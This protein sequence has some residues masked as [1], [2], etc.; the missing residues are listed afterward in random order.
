MNANLNIKT[1][2]ALFAIGIAGGMAGYGLTRTI[3]NTTAEKTPAENARPEATTHLASMPTYFASAAPTEFTSAAEKC[4]DGVVHVKTKYVQ[5]NQMYGN[6]FYQ[7][8]FGMPDMQERQQ[9]A[10]ASGSGVIISNDGYIVTNNHVIEN[11]SSIEVVLNDRR[12]YE[13]Q[14][15]GRDPSTDIALLKINAESLTVIPFG[16]SDNLKIG[17]WVVAIGNPFN[18]TSTVTA[19][20]VSAKG[21][22]NIIGKGGAVESFIQT[23]AAVNPG[24]SG[25]ALVNTEGQLVGINTAIASQTGNFAGYAFAV[26]TSIVQKVISDLMEYG[27]VQRALIGVGIMDITQELAQEK[28]LKDMNGV[29][30]G[31]VNKHSAGDDAGLEAGDVITAINGNKTNSVA[32]L[33]EQVSRFRPGDKAEIT[34]NRKGETRTSEITFKNKENST[35]LNVNKNMELLGA[36]FQE[37]SNKELKNLG[38]RN[39]VQVSDLKSGKFMASGMRKGFIICLVNNTPVSSVDDIQK[40]LENH[41]G[42]V[43]IEG[44]YPNGEAYYYAFGL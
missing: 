31:D 5:D 27:S 32:Q 40:K 6:P 41:K 19:G 28:G 42:G 10:Q 9:M 29:Y 12:T 7:F 3:D 15:I 22:N 20:I 23:D 34:Y 36:T 16:N 8:F 37:L 33:Q 39:G 25:G 14:L 44:M 17:E 4:I 13:A 30:V 2:A 35:D 38:L 11:S 18:L 26:P 21:R 24:N 43:Y 1:M